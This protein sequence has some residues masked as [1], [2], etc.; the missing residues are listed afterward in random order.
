MRA[1]TEKPVSIAGGLL[2][3]VVFGTVWAA[4]KL[5]ELLDFRPAPGPCCPVCG[6]SYETTRTLC[7]DCS[8]SAL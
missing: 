2:A 5:A 7:G 1:T 8:R 4:V 6:R 3:M